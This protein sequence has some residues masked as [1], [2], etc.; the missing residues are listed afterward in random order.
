MNRTLTKVTLALMDRAAR[1]GHP[2]ELAIL[3]MHM[4]HMDGLQ[5]ADAIHRGRVWLAPGW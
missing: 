2:F 4:P 1:S 3:D 5:L